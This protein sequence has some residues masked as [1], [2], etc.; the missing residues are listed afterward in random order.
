MINMKTF[1]RTLISENNQNTSYFKELKHLK[2]WQNCRV[3]YNDIVWPENEFYNDFVYVHG[4]IWQS[5]QAY[6][7][8]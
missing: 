2:R 6:T 1:V 3:K 4:L 8:T 5:S 7:D